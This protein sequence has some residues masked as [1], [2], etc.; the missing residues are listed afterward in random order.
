VTVEVVFARPGL[1]TLLIKALNQH[2]YPVVQAC[3]LML[4]MAVMLGTLLGDLLQAADGPARPGG[5]GMSA[6]AAR[7]QPRVPSRRQRAHLRAPG[8]RWSSG[9]AIFAPLLSPYDYDIQNLKGAFQPPSA[10]HWLGTDEFGRDLLTRLIYGARTS[11]SVS[12]HCHRH[13]GLL[14][15]GAGRGGWFGGKFDPP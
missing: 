11:L 9:C 7:D 8:W 3:L 13:L 12:R 4:A 6:P 10:A 15:H 5:D 1:G 2:D 14:R